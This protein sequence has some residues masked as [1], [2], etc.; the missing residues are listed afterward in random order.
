LSADLFSILAAAVLAL[1]IGTVWTL[2]YRALAGVFG[3]VFLQAIEKFI[4]DLIKLTNSRS[5]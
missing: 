4:T 1:Q 3:V 5:I 2:S